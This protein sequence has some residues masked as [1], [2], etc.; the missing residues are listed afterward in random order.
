MLKFLD[1]ILV[2]ITSL[3]GHAH[4]ELE[5]FFR[6]AIA[7]GIAAVADLLIVWSLVEYAHLHPFMAGAVSLFFGI[8]INFTISRFWSFKSKGPLVKEFVIFLTVAAVGSGINYVTFVVCIGVLHVWYMAAKV[9]AI[10]V[11]WVW[12]YTLNRHVTFKNFTHTVVQ[13]TD[14]K[15]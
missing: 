3:G 7:G 11:A 4:L 1:K 9:I 6:Y 10:G 14:R 12:N 13:S 15:I 8:T 5:L 2:Y